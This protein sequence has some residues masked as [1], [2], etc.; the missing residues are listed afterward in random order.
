LSRRARS[1]ILERKASKAIKTIR[2]T[3]AST[4]TANT[5]TGGR[6]ST[7]VLITRAQAAR[8]FHVSPS[9]VARWATQ[10]LLPYCATLGGQRRYPQGALLALVQQMQAHAPRL[11]PPP[12]ARPGKRR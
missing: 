1:T 7:D 9:T 11:Y 12:P 8:L 10:G 2:A 5:T 3:A 4:T 6:V